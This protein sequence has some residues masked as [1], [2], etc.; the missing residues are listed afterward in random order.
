ME[1][2]KHIEGLLLALKILIGTV[3]YLLSCH[4]LIPLL[5]LFCP[6]IYD[7]NK[8]TVCMQMV[9]GGE[10]QCSRQIVTVSNSEGRVIAC[11]KPRYPTVVSTRLST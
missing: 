5:I 6:Y 3:M 10:A 11:D 8:I 2:P 9:L 4:F 1:R 7:S